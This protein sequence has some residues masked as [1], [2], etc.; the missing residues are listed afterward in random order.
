MRQSTATLTLQFR[1]EKL[2]FKDA[3][4]AGTICL[5]SKRPCPW[6]YSGYSVNLALSDLLSARGS[7]GQQGQQVAHPGSQYK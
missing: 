2:V 5:P 1:D 3:G 4:L 6:T 7:V